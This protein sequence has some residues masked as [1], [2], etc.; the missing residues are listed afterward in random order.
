[1]ILE[2]PDVATFRLA[3]TGGFIP[4]AIA[5]AEVAHSV[6]PSGAVAVAVEFAGKLGKKSAG[7]LEKLGV[8]P[9]ESHFGEARAVGSWPELFPAEK[10]AELPALASSAPVLFELPAPELAGFVHEMLRLGNDR[11]QVRWL[12]TGATTALLR[13]VGPPFYSLLRAMEPGGAVAY[14]EARAARL[15]RVRLPPPVRLTGQGARGVD[16]VRR[17]GSAVADRGRRA[18][19]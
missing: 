9:R 14:A 1:M 10:L 15:G 7:E 18:V 11:Q 19:R 2:F 17:V 12:D 8:T 3:L 5:S 16:A 13:V 4:A 6:G